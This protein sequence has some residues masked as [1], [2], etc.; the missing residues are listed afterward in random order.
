[1]H[2]NKKAQGSK[3]QLQLERDSK[4]RNKLNIAKEF[5]LNLNTVMPRIITIRRISIHSVVNVKTAT[6]YC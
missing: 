1:M 3:K 2:T 4:P 5:Y 6:N